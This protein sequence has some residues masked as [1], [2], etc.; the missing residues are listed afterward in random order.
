MR[1]GSGV[2]EE[3][4]VVRDILPAWPP[5]HALSARYPDAAFGLKLGLGS[6]AFA[7]RALASHRIAVGMSRLGGA[8][9]RSRTA[10]MIFASIRLGLAFSMVRENRRTV[11]KPSACA[12]SKA[13]RP[14]ERRMRR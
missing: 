12:A 13:V 6:A 2:G 11:E 14:R 1:T 8:A 7:E 9:T 10:R 4:A 3:L 5:C